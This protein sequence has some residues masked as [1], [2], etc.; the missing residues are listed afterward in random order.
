MSAKIGA[1]PLRGRERRFAALWL[2]CAWLSACSSA[3]KT[4]VH[5]LPAGVAAQ[6]GSLT[7]STSAVA[8]IAAAQGVDARAARDLAIRDALFANGATARGLEKSPDVRLALR[9]HLARAALRR[10]LTEARST[11]PTEKELADAARRRWLDVDRPEGSLVVHAVV[12]FGETEAADKKAQALAVARAIRSAVVPIASH[13]EANAAP[14]SAVSTAARTATPTSGDIDPLARAFRHA[15]EAVDHAGFDVTIE[16]L[17]AFAPDGRALIA[18]SDAVFEVSFA[19]AAAALPVR[20][21]VSDVVV[22]PFGAHVILLLERT[23]SVS[24]NAEERLLRLRD[25]VINERARASEKK[26][27][28]TRRAATSVASNV[29][30]LLD[31]VPLEP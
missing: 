1:R 8:E 14:P 30:G 28:A 31:L 29:E 22:T 5:A 3:R 18:G 12:R 16:S 25:D 27:L 13:V 17:P 26:L 10:L 23:P 24:L 11:P 7:V 9:G 2:T 4:E 21:A 6:V 19:R 20:G 15:A